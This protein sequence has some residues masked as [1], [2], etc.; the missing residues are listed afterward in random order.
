MVT[1]PWTPQACSARCVTTTSSH[2]PFVAGRH[3]RIQSSARGRTASPCPPPLRPGATSGAPRA[4]PTRTDLTEHPRRLATVRHG[5]LFGARAPYDKAAPAADHQLRELRWPG[6]RHHYATPAEQ[7]LEEPRPARSGALLARPNGTS[8]RASSPTRSSPRST[9][10]SPRAGFR[11]VLQISAPSTSRAGQQ[12]KPP[13]GARRPERR[14]AVGSGRSTRLAERCS[15]HLHT[16]VGRPGDQSA[17][18]F[19]DS[20]TNVYRQPDLPTECSGTTLTRRRR[21]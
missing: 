5:V 9:A 16:P 1:A 17:V 12:S 11:A 7:R 20:T 15:I 14:V 18:L 2:V 10:P 13:G 19:S 4:P 21:S 3:R 8:G 6:L